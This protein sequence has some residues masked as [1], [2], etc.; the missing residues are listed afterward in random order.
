MTRTLRGAVGSPG[1]AV[2]LAYAIDR[3]KLKVPMRMV[4]PEMTLFETGRFRNAVNECRDQLDMLLARDM[5]DEH[6]QI[7]EAHMHWVEDRELAAQIEQIIESERI[8]AEWAVKKLFDNLKAT[9][10][11]DEESLREARANM[12][13]EISSRLLR[14]L[15]GLHQDSMESLPVGV[16]LIAHNVA[17]S[18]MAVIDFRSVEGIAMDM[19][20]PTSHTCILARGMEIPVV[21]ALERATST[22]QT[23]DVVI[24]DAV[25]GKVIVHPTIEQVDEYQEK[26]R[27]IDEEARELLKLKDRPTQTADGTPVRL[28]A[29]LELPQEIELMR[30]YG[31]HDVGLFRSEFICMGR[32]GVAGEEEQYRI[33]SDL[34]RAIGK[35]HIVTIR[36]F[37]FGLD[38][39]ASDIGLPPEA[40]PAMGLRAVRYCLRREDVFKDQLRALL[41]ASVR[42]RL[43]IMFPMIS[44]LGELREVKGVLEEVRQE[45]ELEGIEYA[46]DIETGIMIE[47]PSAALI[48]DALA[49]EVRFFGI[50]TN[51]LIQYALAVDRGNENVAELYRQTHPAVLRLVK[52]AVDAAGKAG[53]QAFMCGEMA[54][55]IQMTMLLIGLGVRHLSSNPPALLRVKKLLRRID[56]A[57]AERFA[58]Q[59]MALDTV[60]EIGAFMAAELMREYPDVF[61]QYNWTIR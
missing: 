59:V 28:W 20:G 58:A 50:G 51:D 38:K 30:R 37:D 40:N 21:V 27:R 14:N 56:V 5:P 18:D 36:T 26:S 24:L 10:T 4:L 16:V 15:M 17:P 53:I 29:N 12:Y 52:M 9:L 2:G 41:R 43:R 46:D 60:E 3:G 6:R 32:G 42:G 47:I 34:L 54:G 25:E 33:Y 45:L 11:T 1:I 39:V 13:D 49:K 35:D 61:D 44:G 8:N 48:A 55:D 19:G 57:R 23:G 7:L 22:I 31:I